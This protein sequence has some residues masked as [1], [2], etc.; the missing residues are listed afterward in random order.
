MNLRSKGGDRK[1]SK[2]PYMRLFTS[3]YR[4]GTAQLSFELQGFYF[5]I[6]TY[7]HDG[8]TVPSDPAK[9]AVFLQ[10]SPR[11]VRA[12]LP[13]LIAAGK[14]YE[15]AGELRNKRVDRDLE[16]NS[17]PIE[18]E[19][20]PNSNRVG[21]EF[22]PNSGRIPEKP[23]SNQ[24]AENHTMEKTTS[25]ATSIAISREDSKLASVEQEPACAAAKLDHLEN[26]LREACNGA[27]ASPA[28]AQ[29]LYDLS[30][31]IMWLKQ[32]CDLEQDVIP[33]LRGIGKR[34]HGKNISSW[35]YFTKPVTEAKRRREAGLPDVSLASPAALTPKKS[36]LSIIAEMEANGEF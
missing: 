30:V 13:K 3:D 9:L 14:L 33:T 23:E 27:L 4:D 1:A 16:P 31:P 36:A 22:E 25:T 15:A 12:Y 18:P 24:S 34:E 17:N 11:T 29:G 5:R 7:L 32:G 8:E 21:A 26:Q 20:E 19:V 10:C 35:S 2:R 28:V 6:L